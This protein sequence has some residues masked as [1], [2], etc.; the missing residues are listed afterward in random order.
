MSMKSRPPN[1]STRR[2]GSRRRCA[3][4]PPPAPPVARPATPAPEAAR[5]AAFIL[6]AARTAQSFLGTV[7]CARRAYFTASHAKGVR[8][9][10]AG[11]GGAR[12]APPAEARLP[13]P[14]ASVRPLPA[15]GGG[16]EG[17]TNGSDTKKLVHFQRV[18]R[19]C[20]RRE[21][22]S[23]PRYAVRAHTLSKRAP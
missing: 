21:W 7:H 19:G 12:P 8:R 6:G 15:G 9:A 23:N 16:K 11:R 13:P 4:A 18:D 5:S 2:P 17:E 3:P 10:V 14:F 20:W 22:D 1:S